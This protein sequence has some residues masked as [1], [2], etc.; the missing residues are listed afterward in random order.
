MNDNKKIAIIT[1]IDCDPNLEYAKR[2][3]D[4]VSEFCVDIYIDKAYEYF[5]GADA[6]GK[7]KYV[8]RAR[9]RLNSWISS[10]CS[11]ATA[12]CL[13]YAKRY[14]LPVFRYSA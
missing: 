11:A 3:I 1:N 13:T 9:T 12:R 14:P 8:T 6:R 10:L 7:V 4:L 5:L 2:I